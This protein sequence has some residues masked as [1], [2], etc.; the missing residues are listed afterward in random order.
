MQVFEE[1]IKEL[2]VKKIRIIATVVTYNRK[3]LLKECLQCLLKQTYPMD[4]L[5]ID[6]ASTDG[7]KEE[8]KSYIDNKKILYLNTGKN[9]GGAG[10]FNYALKEAVK[11]KYDYIWL[12][13]DDTMPQ[14]D[15]L[16]KLISFAQ[17][18]SM[19]FGFLSSKVIWKDGTVCKMN[20]QKF[21]GKEQIDGKEYL[22][23]RQ[24]TFVSLFVPANIVIEEGL[25]IKE[26]FIWGDDVEYTRRISDKYPCFYVQDSVV[27]HKTANNEG[28]NI[29]KD[30]VSRID[31]Y[32][33]AYRN[34]VYIARKEGIKR[35]LYQLLKIIYHIL[36]VLLKSDNYKIRKIA[37][38]LKA[39]AE[40]LHFF[41]EVEYVERN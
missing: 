6:N 27:L 34:E 38:I 11:R 41:P 8:I 19:N 14:E 17:R 2:T 26:F 21:S 39:S 16:S 10:G 9:L 22:M 33:Y 7:T 20:G 35:K 3:E 29:A 5:V 15:A 18:V 36:R 28:S 32:R 30:D 12:M 37:V 31:R 25:P 1:V 4:I 40:G 13:D 23:C 24:A